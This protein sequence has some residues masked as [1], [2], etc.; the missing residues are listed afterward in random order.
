[1]R[2]AKEE[3]VA[4][5]KKK[6]DMKELAKANKLYNEKIAQEKRDARTA[7][8][9]TPPHQTNTCGREILRPRKYW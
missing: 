7:R 3:R 9:P 8:T 2:L 1:M 4:E 5:E 6:A